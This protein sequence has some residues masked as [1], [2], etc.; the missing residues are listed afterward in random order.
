M[1]RR[2]DPFILFALI[3]AF[4]G[5]FFCLHLNL[6]PSTAALL[7]ILIFFLSPFFPAAAANFLYG[8]ILDGSQSQLPFGLH[9]FLA[10]LFVLILETLRKYLRPDCVVRFLILE[11]IFTVLYHA[12]I[13]AFAGPIN[14]KL[15]AFEFITSLGFNV[16]VLWLILWENVSSINLPPVPRNTR[17]HQSCG[18][19]SSHQSRR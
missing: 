10:Y 4:L 17:S 3:S 15:F 11:A 16:L 5:D 19:N 1:K 12:T 18:A 6:W 8:L 13:L 7:P 2:V 9:G 14:F